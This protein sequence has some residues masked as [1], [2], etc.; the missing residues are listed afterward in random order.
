MRSK[1]HTP[2]QLT[3]CR[4]CSGVRGGAGRLPAPDG[5]GG[6]EGRSAILFKESVIVERSRFEKSTNTLKR[7]CFCMVIK[8]IPPRSDFD[9]SS[10]L[11]KA[12][13]QA[14]LVPADGQCIGLSDRHSGMEPQSTRKRASIIHLHILRENFALNV[15]SRPHSSLG[16]KACETGSITKSFPPRQTFTQ[17]PIPISML[18][19]FTPPSRHHGRPFQQS[20]CS[21]CPS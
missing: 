11:W 19:Y 4:T 16:C 17:K 18:R 5:R 1:Q 7:L 2:I 3:S 13:M 21:S 20:R 14:A 6:V 8:I 15:L 9:G 10:R 12:M